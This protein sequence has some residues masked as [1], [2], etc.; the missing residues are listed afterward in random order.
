MFSHRGACS[1]L[2]V[3]EA[4]TSKVI[5]LVWPTDLLLERFVPQTQ[6]PEFS[7]SE[8]VFSKKIAAL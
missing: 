1:V 5:T 3:H 2:T 4:T 7:I 6:V 8:T